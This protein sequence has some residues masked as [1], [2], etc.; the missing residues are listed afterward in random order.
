MSS[1]NLIYIRGCGQ[2]LGQFDTRYMSCIRHKIDAENHLFLS[3]LPRFEHYFYYS[4]SQCG[5]WP[6]DPAFFPIG[7]DETVD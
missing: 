6:N 7:R 5:Q 1:R 4:V 3:E 2:K